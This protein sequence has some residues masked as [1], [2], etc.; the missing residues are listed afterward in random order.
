MNPR[1]HLAPPHIIAALGFMSAVALGWQLTWKPAPA[2]DS[3]VLPYKTRVAHRSNAGPPVWLAD[4]IGQ[5]RQASSFAQRM[6]LTISLVSATSPFGNVCRSG[7]PPAE[8]YP[9]NAPRTFP[10]PPA[11]REPRRAQRMKSSLEPSLSSFAPTPTGGKWHYLSPCISAKASLAA[12]LFFGQFSKPK[13]QSKGG[14]AIQST[15]SLKSKSDRVLRSDEADLCPPGQPQTPKPRTHRPPRLAAADAHE[16]PGAGGVKE[17]WR[18]GSPTD[19][20]QVRMTTWVAARP[21]R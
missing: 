11:G 4:K 3:P 12:S 15:P 17:T 13:N 8:P 1:S 18:E 16:R 2:T 7:C 20:Q 5:L 9:A 19:T 21:S 10:P 6:R 14:R